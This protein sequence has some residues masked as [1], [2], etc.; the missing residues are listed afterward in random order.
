M[1]SSLLNKC[2]NLNRSTGCIQCSHSGFTITILY[3][4][5]SSRR[6]SGSVIIF[7]H[8]Y[9]VGGFCFIISYIER[10]TNYDVKS[11]FKE[12]LAEDIKPTFC[13]CDLNH[14]LQVC[15]N[16]NFYDNNNNEQIK[17]VGM[18]IN[19]L[20]LIGPAD[21]ITNITLKYFCNYIDNV[22]DPIPAC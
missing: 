17:T 13:Q 21:K 3:F 8:V 20:T 14:S 1:S 18:I 10:K 12:S 16:Q 15:H 4:F 11:T 6:P 5:P 19:Q 9:G 2:T 22:I 7:V